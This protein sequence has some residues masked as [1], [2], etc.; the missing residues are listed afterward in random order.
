VF[1]MMLICGLAHGRVYP[2][3][4]V[5]DAGI[6]VS[7]LQ[8]HSGR[9]RPLAAA[10]PP[11][12]SLQD[13]AR[14]EA[15]RVEEALASSRASWTGRKDVASPAN[16]T[17]N[18]QQVFAEEAKIKTEEEA[19]IK[20][21][22]EARIKAEE[23][24][25]VKAEE[26]SKLKAEEEAKAKAAEE[27][28][29]KAEEED[30]DYALYLGPG[31]QFCN[32]GVLSASRSRGRSDCQQRCSASTKCKYISLWSTGGANWC[33]LTTGC[34]KKAVQAQHTINVYANR[35]EALAKAAENPADA[36]EVGLAKNESEEASKGETDE[37][38]ETAEKE[39]RQLRQLRELR[40]L[41]GIQT[42]ERAEAAEANE[43]EHLP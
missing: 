38:D 9:G 14:R 6:S 41:K 20:A 33:Q 1:T 26:E 31:S 3:C 40:Q 43:K 34:T 39:K 8:A 32:D 22:K 28:R 15:V 13:R 23:E 11:S 12:E 36:D 5:D 21:E 37:A 35:E 25:R 29:M 24:A 18:R 42:D 2:T 27:A 19:R 4:E 16:W 7:L 10:A 17:M 30:K